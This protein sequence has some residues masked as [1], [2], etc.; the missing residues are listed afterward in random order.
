ML[1]NIIW[2]TAF[3][4]TLDGIVKDAVFTDSLAAKIKFVY[5]NLKSVFLGK[6]REI[7]RVMNKKIA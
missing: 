3:G 5:L 1:Q 6:I 2:L 7:K 4:H